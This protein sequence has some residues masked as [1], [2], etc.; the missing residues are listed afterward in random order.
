MSKTL[1][2]GGSGFV[3]RALVQELLADGRQ[4]RVLARHP[5]H[6]ALQGLAVEV[7]Q[8]DL[9][10][11]DSLRIALEGCSYLFHVAADYRLWVPNPKDMYAT[12]VEGTRHIL[13]A[14][15]ERGLER[16]VYTST[17]GT[18]GNPGDGTPGRE[19]TPVS[20]ADMVG[21]YKKSK[22]LAEQIALEFARRGLPI[23][24]VNPSTPVGPWDYRPTPTGQMIVDFLNG[25]MPAYLDSGLN[26]IHVRDVARGHILAEERGRPGE[27]YILGHQNLSLSEIF[28]ILAGI[29]QRPAPR[30]R[31]PYYP[32]LGLAY[33]N[34]FWA[35]WVSHRPPRIPLT[36]VKMAGKFMYFDSSKAM[37]ELGLPQTPVREALQ[38]A[39]TWFQKHGYVKENKV[40]S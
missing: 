32:I 16:V 30:W 27:K 39:I 11:P 36:A 31:L 6:P 14:A 28:E 35:T 2:T 40:Q 19:D 24:L 22:F 18:L 21:H 38:D 37:Q 33:V 29:S 9:R 25:Q 12:N 10:H 20:F 17:V 4:V 3:G 15:W 5:E 26:L 7:V 34:E 1:V 8:G 13:R 23:V